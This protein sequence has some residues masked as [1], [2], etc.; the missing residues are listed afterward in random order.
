MAV[1]RILAA[2]Q[3]LSGIRLFQAG[4]NAQQGGFAT[5]GRP[6]QCQQLAGINRQADI[7]KRNELAEL[8]A[9]GTDFDTHALLSRASSPAC[10]RCACRASTT[11][12]R[13]RSA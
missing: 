13:D 9:N 7:V 6:K 4:D 3:H 8:L 10:T 11:L 1:G 12:T 5:A 2:K